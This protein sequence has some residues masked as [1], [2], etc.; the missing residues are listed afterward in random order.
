MKQVIIMLAHASSED[1]N[2]PLSQ[3][4]LR[5]PIHIACSVTCLPVVQLLLWVRLFL[6]L[7]GTL[8]YY[9]ILI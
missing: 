6:F 4:D 3:R 5:R 9:L 8:L 2:A 1:I 7:G